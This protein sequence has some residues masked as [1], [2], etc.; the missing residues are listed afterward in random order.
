MACRRVLC[1][2]LVGVALTA[3]VSIGAS[4]FVDGLGDRLES[5]GQPTAF[6]IPVGKGISVRVRQRFMSYLVSGNS[7]HEVQRSLLKSPLQTAKGLAFGITQSEIRGTYTLGYTAYSCEFSSVRLDLDLVIVIPEL[8]NSF[9]TKGEMAHWI[10][11]ADGV[12]AHE[13]IHAQDYIDSTVRIASKVANL[14]ELDACSAAEQMYE[15]IVA[16]EVAWQ[17]ARAK[18]VDALKLGMPARFK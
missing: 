15:Q 18:Y 11:Y 17:N 4:S 10:E 2:V 5:R 14:G 7:Y 9:L 8:R 6:E 12:M 1:P 13:K 16:D 3:P